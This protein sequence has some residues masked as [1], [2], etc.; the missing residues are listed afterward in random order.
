M[1]GEIHDM[2]SER[3]R[4][5]QAFLA[6]ILEDSVA[7][8]LADEDAEQYLQ[9]VTV[10][11]ARRSSERAGLFDTSDESTALATNFG[12]SIWNAFPLP[13]NGFRPRPLAMPGRNDA[14]PCGS[15]RKFKRCCGYGAAAPGLNPDVLWPMLIRKLSGNALD[16]AIADGLI[17]AAA[18]IGAAMDYRDGNRPKL[19]IK[20]LEPIFNEPLRYCDQDGEF[21]FDLLCGLYDDLGYSR[22]KTGLLDRVIAAA[23]RSPLRSGA[24]Q[25]LAAIRMDEGDSAGAWQAFK[26]AQRDEPDAPSLGLLEVQLLLAQG[27]CDVA[28]DRARFWTRRLRSLGYPESEGVLPLLE[29]VARDPGRA[30]GELGIEISGGAGAR[31]LDWLDRVSDRAVPDYRVTDKPSNIIGDDERDFETALA[32]RVQELGVPEDD[33]SDII[34][35]MDIPDEPEE[36][37]LP[38]S[39]SNYL[40]APATVQSMELDWHDVFS[41]GKPFSVNMLA[42]DGDLWSPAVENEWM[43]FLEA[44]EAAFDSLDILDD[45]ANAVHAHEQSSMAGFDELLLQPILR[46][47]EVIIQLAVSQHD[48]VR[49]AWVCMENRPALRCLVNL[50]YLEERLGNERAMVD[51]AEQVLGLNPD[52]NHGLRCMIINDH[53]RRDND[54]GAL[55]L[56]ER[57]PADL[58]P[59]IAYGHALALFRLGRMGDANAAIQDAVANLPKVPRYLLAKRIRQ[60]KL[61]PVGVIFGGDDQAWLYRQEMRVVWQATPGALDWIKGHRT[62]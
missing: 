38:E 5:L 10:E 48:G 28:A 24:R 51:I 37:P 43:T 18:L 52:D 39:E 1:T 16:G 62:A 19:A 40:L 7:Q 22:K 53:L 13:G 50:A 23:E 30:L 45:L 61:D 17:P 3:D 59:D 57:Y 21:A 46:R 9:W 25:R 12:R 49:L 35:D 56:A 58:N 34:T 41:L 33:V 27:E 54:L 8:I 2:I 14:C 32:D 31:L 36:L 26:L 44:N 4:Q 15:G 6:E 60:P 29:Q 55:R 42:P 11:F 47:A 20:I